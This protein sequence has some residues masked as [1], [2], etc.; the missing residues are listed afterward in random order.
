MAHGVELLEG[1][2]DAGFAAAHA[3]EGVDGADEEIDGGFDFGAVGEVGE[4]EAAGEHVAE[5]GLDFPLGFEEFGGVVV[6]DFLW[7][8][9]VDEF[10]EEFVGDA[11]WAGGVVEDEVDDGFIVEFSS[12][13][14]DGFFA[15]VEL[16]GV[17]FGV[18]A[19]DAPAG[20][21][22]GDFL[23]VLLGVVADAEGE[24]FHEFAG[25]VFVGFAFAVLFAV[26]PDEHGGVVADGEE[27]VAEV[28]QAE[29]SEEVDLADDVHGVLVFAEAGGEGVV[30]EECD[31]FLE[32]ARGFEEAEDPP[33]LGEFGFVDGDEAVEIVEEGVE[34]VVV[35]V[36]GEEEVEDIGGGFAWGGEF[37]EAVGGVAEGGAAEEV[38]EPAAYRRGIG[39]RVC[40]GRRGGRGG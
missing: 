10:A 40:R 38:G 1:G 28:S 6:D 15:V 21:G 33:L 8:V 5:D 25:V 24:E 31:A 39:R 26:E 11:A 27:E 17:E 30:P 12:L 36:V 20:E 19:F 29:A 16:L 23:D 13:A 2:F 9:G 22:A 34:G 35:G 7:R 14:E 32:G 3:D 4:E 18:V 37:F